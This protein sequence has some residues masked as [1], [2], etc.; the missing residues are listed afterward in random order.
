M[1]HR[2]CLFE[3]RWET[4]PD[5]ALQVQTLHVALVASIKASDGS[6]KGLSSVS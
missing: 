6:V 1:G 4:S 5:V 2:P 3:Q